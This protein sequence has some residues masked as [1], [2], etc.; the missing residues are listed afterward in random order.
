MKW[1]SDWSRWEKDLPSKG[2]VHDACISLL[3]DHQIKEAASAN[4]TGN[5]DNFITA[6]TAAETVVNS[7]CGKIQFLSCNPREPSTERSHASNL[8]S[9]A[10]HVQDGI[11][12]SESGLIRAARISRKRPAKT[13][14]PRQSKRR[15]TKA[16]TQIPSSSN[17]QSS[18]S[19]NITDS[20]RRHRPTSTERRSSCDD[21]NAAES[22]VSIANNRP[23]FV[24]QDGSA[25]GSFTNSSYPPHIEGY[26]ESTSYRSNEGI[27]AGSNATVN[28]GSSLQ[29]SEHQPR[30]ESTGDYQ[31][32]NSLR[33]PIPESPSDGG[34]DNTNRMP[35]SFQENDGASSHSIPGSGNPPSDDN[36]PD[37]PNE[38]PLPAEI[39]LATEQSNLSVSTDFDTTV[40]RFTTPTDCTPNAVQSN[41]SDI[42]A[43]RILAV[44]DDGDLF[45]PQNISAARSLND[46][47][48]VPVEEHVSYD[49]LRETS[50][51]A[52]VSQAVELL[53]NQSL[54]TTTDSPSQYSTAMRLEPT[55]TGYK[56]GSVCDWSQL[57]LSEFDLFPDVP[58]PALDL[59]EIPEFDGFLSPDKT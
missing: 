52:H 2:E 26:S 25:S 46:R 56:D 17:V 48:S 9:R 23:L 47:N 24:P 50:A 20:P 6:D 32:S 12:S 29:S 55:M 8:G 54:R 39:M 16:N 41:G 49:E 38:A 35:N 53:G 1:L 37:H 31:L 34:T 4:V 14:N 18:Q 27:T 10:S 15:Q 42:D 44:N 33:L 57:D 5:D 13:H 43:A 45:V 11:P 28:P 36:T 51:Q 58:L 19:N 59:S 21:I 22:L 7:L 30:N 3:I 40:S